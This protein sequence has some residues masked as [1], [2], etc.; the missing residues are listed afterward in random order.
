MRQVDSRTPL[1]TLLSN[2]R[3]LG[4]FIVLHNNQ[5][6]SFGLESFTYLLFS[7]SSTLFHGS[8]DR[9]YTLTS[10]V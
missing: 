10:L 7:D 4:F 8:E 6:V 3:T 9:I 1:L 5:L 2:F